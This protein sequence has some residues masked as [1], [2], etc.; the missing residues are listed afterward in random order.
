MTPPSSPSARHGRTLKNLALCFL[1]SGFALELGGAI[2]GNST[3]FKV[4]IFL[5]LMGIPLLALGIFLGR[6]KP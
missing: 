6:R 1:L 4:G 5:F 2:V 3:V